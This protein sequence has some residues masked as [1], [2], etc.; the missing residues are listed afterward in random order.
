[1][2]SKSVQEFEALSL[3]EKVYVA[4]SSIHGKG[5]FA[6]VDVPKG[7]YIGTY[8][9]PKAK[10]DSKFTLWV[11]APEK[12]IGRVGRNALKYLNHSDTPNAEFSEFDLYASTAIPAGAEITFDYDP[13]GENEGDWWE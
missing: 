2:P 6:K 12:P 8:E 3:E 4:S 1:M 13:D 5:C 9:G 7:A 10:R 11:M